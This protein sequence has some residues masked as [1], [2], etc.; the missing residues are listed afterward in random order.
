MTALEQL[1]RELPSLLGEWQAVSSDAAALESLMNLLEQR[2]CVAA[3]G[4]ED[5]ALARV[6]ELQARLLAKIDAEIADE[7]ADLRDQLARLNIA[8]LRIDQL[9]LAAAASSEQQLNIP[10]TLPEGAMRDLDS[11]VLFMRQRHR[12]MS[13]LFDSLDASP[14][15]ERV[16]QQLRPLWKLP[17]SMRQLFTSL[18]RDFAV[19][20]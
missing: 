15:C 4:N 17:Y 14:K 10:S 13:Q 9:Y 7:C 19:M 16:A 3:T 5:C 11:V 8:A 18:K 6:P 12:Q 2:S 20:L 1:A